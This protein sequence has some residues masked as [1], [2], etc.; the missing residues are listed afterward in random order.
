[1]TYNIGNKMRIKTFKDIKDNSPI[2][3]VENYQTY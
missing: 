1:M 3:K 2:R